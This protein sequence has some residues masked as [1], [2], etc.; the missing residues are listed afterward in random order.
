M[1]INKT[2]IAVAVYDLHTQA[3][4]F[5]LVVHGDA[6][7]IK[8]AHELLETSGLASFDHH[9]SLDETPSKVHA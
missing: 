6:R 5:M 3:D 9:R 7:E 8:R 4:K 1:T 2:D